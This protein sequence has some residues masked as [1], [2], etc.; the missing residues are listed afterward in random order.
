M[1][2]TAWFWRGMAHSATN[3]MK[4]ARTRVGRCW[5]TS[6]L[7]FWKSV[8]AKVLSSHHILQ[9]LPWVHKFRPK[10]CAL[11]YK[12]MEELRELRVTSRQGC[13]SYCTEL[14]AEELCSST[15]RFVS[16]HFFLEEAAL[17]ECQKGRSRII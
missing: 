7:W 13:G 15:W 1:R 17:Q 6:L 9:C 12:W 16:D 14:L 2:S 11:C 4:G 3:L 8:H 10:S 5:R